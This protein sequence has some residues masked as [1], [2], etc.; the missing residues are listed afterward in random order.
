MSHELFFSYTPSD[1]TQGTIFEIASS[2]TTQTF[3]LIENA[4]IFVCINEGSSE[5]LAMTRANFT[6]GTYLWYR[7]FSCS[8]SS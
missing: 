3:T 1:D 4:D 5:D 2:D 6:S 7:V 8:T